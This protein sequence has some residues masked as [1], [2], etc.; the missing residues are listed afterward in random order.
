MFQILFMYVVMSGRIQID[1]VFG[2]TQ[3]CWLK[4]D[5]FLK[6]LLR[7]NYTLQWFCM[8]IIRKRFCPK[9]NNCSAIYDSVTLVGRGVYEFSQAKITFLK[10][11]WYCEWFQNSCCTRGVKGPAAAKAASTRSQEWENSRAPRPF[12]RLHLFSPIIQG[13]APRDIV[14]LNLTLSAVSIGPN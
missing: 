4:V 1:S 7:E 8:E 3:P 13:Q 14:S 12:L 11:L 2:T 9:I 6:R 10:E 5:W